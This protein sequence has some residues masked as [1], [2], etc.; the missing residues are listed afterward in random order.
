MADLKD[1]TPRP[2]RID[3]DDRPG[4]HWNNHI[5]CAG[6]PNL[7]IC[8]MTHD[9]TPENETG[10]ANAAL[11]VEAVNNYDR[12]RAELAEATRLLRSAVSIAAEAHAEWDADN[13]PRV[14]KI[15]IAL[16]GGIPGYRK[17]TDEIRA[18]LSRQEKPN[19]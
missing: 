8:F 19:G 12:L 5:V 14:G 17:D 6:S 2:W 10:D 11:I 7:T 18:F 4:M 13:D 16:S 1:A 9:N 3:P 15:L